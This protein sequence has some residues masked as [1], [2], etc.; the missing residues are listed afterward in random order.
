MRIECSKNLLIQGINI[1][2][3]AVNNKTT[4]PI[5]ECI[6][7]IADRDGFRLMSND[8]E[9]SIETANIDCDVFDLGKVAVDARIFSN[10]I[11]SMSGDMISIETDD[12]F[13]TVIKS[14]RSEF[15]IPGQDGAEFPMPPVIEKEKSLS[16]KNNEFKNMIKK[17]V[18][19][20]ST[21]AI[22]PV[23]TGE[24]M[25]IEGKYLN[26]VAIDGH[27]I[28][29]RR[30]ILDNFDDYVEFVVP[31]KTL[32]EI[33][34]IGSDNDNLINIYFNDRHIV[35][36]MEECTIVSRLLEGEYL[37]YKA[38]FKTEFKTII[39]VNRDML[40]SSLERSLLIS[41]DN[42]S[43]PVKISVENDTMNINAVTELG[44]VFD[45]IPVHS[46][47]E[48]IVIYFNPKYLIDIVR[49]VDEEEVSMY[50]IGG[51]LAPCI[52]KND[53]DDVGYKYL[54]LPLRVNS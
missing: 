41:K 50:F 13:L 53:N 48:N 52:I 23:L 14:D 54:V 19:S 8:L 24:F 42:K 35:F 39:K 22:R 27:R 51:P 43:T 9:L 26:V 5:L 20:V 17:T 2:M 32:N 46:E 28:S 3:K 49:A 11:K 18:F 44:Q 33:T 29:H 10:I 25:E 21:E 37:D 30:T 4:L 12:S 7:L 31:A 47:G 38:N 34:R 40:L 1:V 36:K 16:I 15:K 45:E 6:L